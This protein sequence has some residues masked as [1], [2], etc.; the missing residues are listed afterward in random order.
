VRARAADALG[1]IGDARA[2]EP[3]YVVASG[4]YIQSEPT[5]QPDDLTPHFSTFYPAAVKPN[6]PYALMAFVHV[7]AALA[8]VREIAAG[9]IGMMGGQQ[10]SGT[11]QSQIT[12]DVG[13]AITFVPHMPGIQFSPAESVVMWLPPNQSATF[14]FTTPADLSADL[15]GRVAVYQGPLIIGEIPVHMKLAAADAPVSAGLNRQSELQR[16]DPI[17]ASYSHRDTPVMEYFRRARE[18]MGQKMLVDIYELRAGEHWADRLL[19]MIDQCA[20]F[21]L[22]W[23]KHSAQSKYCRQE[24]EHALQHASMRPRFIQPVW[25]VAPMPPPPSELANLH[26]QKVMVPPAQ[27]ALTRM[28]RLFRQK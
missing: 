24:W 4:R 11:A 21:Q 16:F 27:L 22:F 5:R 10:E 8:Q 23:S 12:V 3:S 15:I 19:E 1:E 20:V 25:W 9:F 13:S 6:Q 14:L 17:F 26:F 2:V 7:E 18:N 28:R